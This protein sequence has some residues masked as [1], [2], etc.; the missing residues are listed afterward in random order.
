M[1]INESTKIW[2][3]VPSKRA[4]PTPS[5]G[6]GHW[7]HRRPDPVQA[8]VWTVRNS[9]SL[10]LKILFIHERHTERGRG[11]ERG[12]SRLPAGNLMRETGLQDPRITT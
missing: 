2:V 9:F 10:F 6:S 11:I 12:R 3:F 8:G 7:A 4:V 1:A 5:L